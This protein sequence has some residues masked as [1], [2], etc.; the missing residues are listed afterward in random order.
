MACGYGTLSAVLVRDRTEY[1]C[2]GVPPEK[3]VT[4]EPRENGATLA[5]IGRILRGAFGATRDR[6]PAPSDREVPRSG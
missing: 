4:P 6:A 2:M 3:E 5:A 1:V